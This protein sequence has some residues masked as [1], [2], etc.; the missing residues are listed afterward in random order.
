MYTIAG[1]TIELLYGHNIDSACLNSPQELLG[2]RI[3]LL[4][5]L[6][7]WRES[8]QPAYSIVTAAEVDESDSASFDTEKF[9]ILLSIQYYRLLL[10]I[11]GPII[12]A[13][14]NFVIVEHSDKMGLGLLM[15]AIG[16]VIMNDIVAAKEVQGIVHTVT[17][18]SESFWDRNAAW[19]T[20]NY[21][22][23]WSIARA[24]LSTVHPLKS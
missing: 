4:W 23:K 5:Q 1:S 20:S 15:E 19:L 21:T 10:L 7:K 13:F 22:S 17:V 6:G 18:T 14:L 11:N 8:L 12:T 9:Q 24:N 3:Q 2:N 16:S